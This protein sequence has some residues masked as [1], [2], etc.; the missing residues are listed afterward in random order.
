MLTLH[1]SCFL[2]TSNTF[3]SYTLVHDRETSVNTLVCIV[4]CRFNLEFQTKHHFQLSAC[5]HYAG[6]CVSILLAR[7][8][9]LAQWACAPLQLPG[10]LTLAGS[11]RHCCK[12]W[13]AP[14]V[15][16][17]KP[18]TWLVFHWKVES[19][20]T[21]TSASTLLPLG[22]EGERTHFLGGVGWPWLFLCSLWET[23]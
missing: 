13:W 2:C 3:L 6:V 7:L 17:E 14:C 20:I 16:S 15:H 9:F 4:E 21:G 12:L 11:L 19:V 1:I 18:F 23:G 10:R 8:T 5:I 22:P